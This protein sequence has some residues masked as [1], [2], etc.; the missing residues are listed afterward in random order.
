MVENISKGLALWIYILGALC[1][2]FNPQEH[3]HK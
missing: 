1:I 2:F 3:P